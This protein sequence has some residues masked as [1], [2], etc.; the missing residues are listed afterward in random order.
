[1]KN[2]FILLSSG[3]FAIGL[4]VVGFIVLSNQNGSATRVESDNKVSTPEQTTVREN[5]VTETPT[6]EDPP[7]SMNEETIENQTGTYTPYSKN[8]LT[9][10]TNVIFFAASW[11]PTCRALDRAINENLSDIPGELTILK[12]D[13]DTETALKQKYGVTYQHTMVQ[14]DQDGNQIKKWNGGYSVEDIVENIT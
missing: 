2:K 11:C 13:Y 12:A 10:K 14:V 7:A 4:A 1:M 6:T 3:V 9:D 5:D 8:A